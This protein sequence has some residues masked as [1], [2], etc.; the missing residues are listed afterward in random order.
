MADTKFTDGA[1]ALQTNPPRVI[2]IEATEQPQ[3]IT[4]R[5]AAYARVS[6]SSDDQLNSFAAQTNY[7]NALISGKENWSLVDIYAD[8]G[9]TGTSAEKRGDFQRLLTDC[10]RGL[11]DRVLVKSIS[12]FAR[13]TKECL[14]VI[15]ELKLLGVSVSFEKEHIDTATMSGEMLTSIFASMAQAESESISGNMRWSYQKRMES[16]TFITCKRPYGYHLVD[17][18]LHIYEPEAKIVRM[19]FD[20]YLAGRSSVEIADQINSIGIPARDGHSKWQRSTIRYI[21]QNE[22]YAGYAI[23]QKYYSTDTLPTQKRKN[24]GERQQYLVPASNPCIVSQEI[25][26]ATQSLIHL[27][28]GKI[29]TVSSK[30]ILSQKIRCGHCGSLF[31]RK[32]TRGCVYWVCITHN[33]TKEYCPIPQ[34]PEKEFY[35]AF[36]RMY[37]KLKHHGTPI[38]AQMLSQLQTI[39]NRRM[40]W[41]PDVVELNN[42][43]SDLSRQNQMLATLKQQGLIDPDIFIAQSNELTKQLRDAKL[44]K[45]RLLDADSDSTAA[46]TQELMDVL[47][48]GPDFLDAFDAE[49]FGEL[50]DKIIVDSSTQLRFRLKN[51]LE[52]VESIEKAVR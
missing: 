29:Q 52:L 10:R 37:F 6:S 12:R 11:I 44:E 39:R 38:L 33:Q 40:L 20:L 3:D 24:L 7:Y 9:I 21:L 17:G 16:G 42:R 28:A 46:Q 26:S 35:S 27:R 15:R 8:E 18:K 25:F 1:T 13:N 43:L 34:L 45:E 51:G 5:V 14:E 41:S 48:A 50:V 19:I 23:L 2:T 49:L 47:E 22:R 30:A 32:L 36:Q 4:L 31:R